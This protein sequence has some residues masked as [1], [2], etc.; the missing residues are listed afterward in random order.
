LVAHATRW[1]TCLNDGKV[2]RDERDRQWRIRRLQLAQ[3][4]I[5]RA[6]TRHNERRHVRRDDDD[7]S[8][9]TIERAQAEALR[10]PRDNWC[11]QRL[12]L[13]V[14]DARAQQFGCPLAP[15]RT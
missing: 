7:R 5:T 14:A 13:R 12:R 8:G 11:G 3:E 1:L 15:V 6:W 4:S 10:S 9:G 2:V